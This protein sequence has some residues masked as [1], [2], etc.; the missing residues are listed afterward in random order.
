MQFKATCAI[1]VKGDHIRRGSVIELT[2]EEAAA[3]G[4]DLMP[5]SAASA[6]AE[7]PAEIIAPE[8]MSLAQLKEHAKALGLPTGGS[9]ADLLERIALN[10]G[11]PEPGEEPEGDIASE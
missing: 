8:D 3:F 10:S 6:P 2:P 1:V 5:L 9:K 4:S 7:E 11:A